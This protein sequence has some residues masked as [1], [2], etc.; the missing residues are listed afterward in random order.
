MSTIETTYLNALARL[1]EAERRLKSLNPRK[2]KPEKLLCAR[3]DV[4]A[5]QHIV[6]SMQE[7][8]GFLAREDAA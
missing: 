8:Y 6:R 5:W 1:R 4:A 7:Q 2:Q 3:N